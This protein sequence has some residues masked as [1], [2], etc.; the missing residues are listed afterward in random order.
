[1]YHLLFNRITDAL[2]LLGQGGSRESVWLLIHAQ[3]E[4]EGLY[5]EGDGEEEGSDPPA[6]GSF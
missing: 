2:E 6:C 3:Q 1:M 5:L 4:T